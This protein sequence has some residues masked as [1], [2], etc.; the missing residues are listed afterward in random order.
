MRI[1]WRCCLFRSA[2][3]KGGGGE[4]GREGGRN[5]KITEHIGGRF[6][7]KRRKEIKISRA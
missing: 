2:E 3:M 7:K 1:I 4:G 5:T 6:P